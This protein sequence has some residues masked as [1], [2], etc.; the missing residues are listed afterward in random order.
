MFRDT[1]RLFCYE[2]NLSSY[3]K[4][5]RDKPVF[6]Y[7]KTII[8]AILEVNPV[9]TQRNLHISVS[10]TQAQTYRF[11]EFSNSSAYQWERSR[12]VERKEHQL[13]ISHWNHRLSPQR[14][15]P[16]PLNPVS[17]GSVRSSH[18]H[19]RLG[20]VFQTANKASLKCGLID[21]NQEPSG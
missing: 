13:L 1:E 19:T 16:G 14:F 4:K 9:L 5:K 2:F 6:L 12:G 7:I 8:T 21:A 3:K 11:K 15:E 18:P 20:L 10:Q 17:R